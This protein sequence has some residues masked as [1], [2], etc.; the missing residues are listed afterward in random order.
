[1]AGEKILVVDDNLEIGGAIKLCLESE[2]MNVTYITNGNEVMNVLGKNTFDLMLL[3]LVL[4]DADGFEILRE[5]RTKHSVLPVILISAKNKLHNKVLGLGLGADDYITKPFDE[6]ELIARVK[7]H[8]RR[9]AVY[10][11]NAAGSSFL[12]FET[13]K[14]DLNS[15]RLYK[16][17]EEIQLNAR[18]F[19]ILKMFMEQPERAFSKAQIYEQAWDDGFY[20]DNVVMIYI[21]KLRKIIEKDPNN[22]TLIKTIRGVGY[23]LTKNDSPTN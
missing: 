13:L 11:Q 4:G 17:V 15:L 2:N 21:R 14:L 22:P 7:T 10:Q 3:D 12:E 1:M 18:M 5:V 23:M 20:D 8:I 16:G 9:T 19:K 6:D